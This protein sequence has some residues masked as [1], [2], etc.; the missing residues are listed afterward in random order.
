VEGHVYLK[1]YK[2]T[3]YKDDLDSNSVD[4]G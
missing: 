3:S 1:T 4:P 2:G